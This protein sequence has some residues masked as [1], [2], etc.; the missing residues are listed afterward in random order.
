MHNYSILHKKHKK[1]KKTT[2]KAGIIHRKHHVQDIISLEIMYVYLIFVKN[3]D[4]ITHCIYYQLDFTRV[5]NFF[6]TDFIF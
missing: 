6:L 1:A 3:I 4:M 5:A 2:R